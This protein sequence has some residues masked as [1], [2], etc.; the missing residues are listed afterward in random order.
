MGW[1]LISRGK[2][3]LD[4]TT[5]DSGP[6]S[7]TTGNWRF[8]LCLAVLAIAPYLNAVSGDFIWDDRLFLVDNPNLERSDNVLQRFFS[9][10]I[11][12][13]SVLQTQ[14]TVLYRP[15][16]TLAFWVNYQ[17]HGQNPLG[18][19]L[20][21]VLLHLANTL[22]V[23]WLLRRQF[24]Q[25]SVGAR[26]AGTAIFAVHPVHVESIAWISAF[27]DPFASI[28]I[29]LGVGLWRESRW[30]IASGIFLFAA[31]CF[32]EVALGMLPLLLLWDL[33]EKRFKP[34]KYLP[35]LAAV[36]VYFLLRSAALGATL[37]PLEL[38]T[39]PIVDALSYFALYLVQC[40]WP[41][42]PLFFYGSAA[43]VDLYPDLIDGVWLAGIGLAVWY[44]ARRERQQLPVLL[45]AALWFGSMMLP[46]MRAVFFDPQTFALRYL[47]IP[48]IAFVLLVAV[49]CDL[50]LKHKK[51]FTVSVMTVLVL[52]CAMGTF[53]L[54]RNWQDEGSFFGWLKT[55][56]PNYAGVHYGLAD[57]LERN[58]QIGPVQSPV[59]FWASHR[60]RCT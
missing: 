45:F 27:M 22:L 18:Y 56:S 37:P 33:C 32:K 1:G 11:W 23:W 14:D 10:G 5:A 43:P 42:P 8:L 41:W 28:F 36:V 31:L 34:G 20:F 38:A 24:G 7:G 6:R 19:H 49:L 21:S 59:W 40:V 48:S 25:L 17:I 57:Y 44:A 29:L 47:Y 16:A 9:T 4:R 52:L 15:L 2:R 50:G 39:I 60:V 13:H 12:D 26:F 58:G 46:A 53:S 51:R 54:N 30:G 35:V 55:V 3:S